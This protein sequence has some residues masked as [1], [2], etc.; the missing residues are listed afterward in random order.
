M[1]IK[2]DILRQGESKYSG[3][4]WQG[5]IWGTS[6]YPWPNPLSTQF[7][8]YNGIRLRPSRIPPSALQGFPLYSIVVNEKT[9]RFAKYS[10]DKLNSYYD[11]YYKSADGSYER[12]NFATDRNSNILSP[13]LDDILKSV[14]DKNQ[15]VDYLKSASKTL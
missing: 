2:A 11:Y 13:S 7:T 14:Q 1:Y 12:Y 6:D 10:D 3:N 5:G 15:R 9:Y 8:G 4:Y